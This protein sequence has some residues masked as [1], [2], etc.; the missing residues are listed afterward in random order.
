VTNS[1]MRLMVY[2]RQGLPHGVETDEW[3]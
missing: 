1:E 2:F 3:L